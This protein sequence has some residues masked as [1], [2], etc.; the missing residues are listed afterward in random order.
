MARTVK[1]EEYAARRNEILDVALRLMVT[2]GYESVTIREILD[3]IKISSGAFHHYFESREALLEAMIGRLFEQ[4]KQALLPLIR[5]PN[6]PAIEK[7][8]GFF[9]TLDRMRVERKADVVRLGRV[10]YAENN[11]YVRH[12][13]DEAAFEYRGPLLNE[14]VRQGVQEGVFTIAHPDQAG[15]V[16]LALLQRMSNLHAGVLFTA[17]KETEPARIEDMVECIVVTH[18]AFMDAIE[19]ALGAPPNSLYRAD[20]ETARWWV[21]T[22]REDI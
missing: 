18:A 17:M 12:R 8:K 4:S 7:L 19:R 15:Q 11:A 20:T 16:I 2:K 22:V 13:V 9:G 21:D 14:I 3:E 1:P 10:W 6:L 5:D